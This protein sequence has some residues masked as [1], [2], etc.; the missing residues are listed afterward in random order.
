VLVAEVDL[1]EATITK[2]ANNR[3]TFLIYQIFRIQIYNRKTLKESATA[4]FYVR[5]FVTFFSLVSYLKKVKNQ[6]LK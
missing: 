1:Q 5:Q 2:M 4:F 6:K 3:I